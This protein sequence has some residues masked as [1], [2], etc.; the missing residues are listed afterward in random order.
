MYLVQYLNGC[1]LGKLISGKLISMLVHNQ[2]QQIAVIIQQLSLKENFSL[3]STRLLA[4]SL[5]KY[6]FVCINPFQPWL[7]DGLEPWCFSLM[8]VTPAGCHCETT[9]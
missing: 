9:A 7:V 2:K 1:L 3:C 4:S 5:Q 6:L 8:Y